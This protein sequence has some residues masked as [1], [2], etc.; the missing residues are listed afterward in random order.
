[1]NTDT[2]TSAAIDTASSLIEEVIRFRSA[3]GEAG[4]KWSV[5][6]PADNLRFLREEAGEV[7]KEISK[8]TTG[9]AR[10]SSKTAN[11]LAIELGDCALMWAT[12]MSYLGLHKPSKEAYVSNIYDVLH[13]QDLPPATPAEDVMCFHA[14]QA[15]LVY[16][17]LASQTYPPRSG[18]RRLNSDLGM[19]FWAMRE[20]AQRNG[21]GLLRDC[22]GQSFYKQFNNHWPA[23]VSHQPY[24]FWF[25]D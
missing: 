7:A 10:N 17:E 8:A 9:Y 18:F 1:M 15:V 14:S 4:S 22:L 19:V 21:L 5:P 11:A 23:G 16:L 3:M 20:V 25:L 2:K 12:S 24:D 6:S 13:Q